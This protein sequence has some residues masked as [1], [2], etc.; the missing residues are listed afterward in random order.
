MSRKALTGTIEAVGEVVVWTMLAWEADVTA[1][2]IDSALPEP[3]DLAHA[4]A[5]ALRDAAEAVRYAI[6]QRMG[7]QT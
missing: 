2:L 1:D 6:R 3:N 5:D 4:D 7:G